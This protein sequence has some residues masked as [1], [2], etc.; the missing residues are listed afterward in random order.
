MCNQNEK[1][2][3]PTMGRGMSFES[4]ARLPGEYIKLNNKDYITT[5]PKGETLSHL[6]ASN[7]WKKMHGTQI[8]TIQNQEV[9]VINFRENTIQNE[10]K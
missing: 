4:K 9:Q 1:I 2:A 6:N 5:D 8:K 10:A 3:L 7:N